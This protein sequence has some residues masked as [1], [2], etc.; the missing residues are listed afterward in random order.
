MR[1]SYQSNDYVVIDPPSELLTSGRID[2][3]NP[4]KVSFCIPTLNNETT[5]GSCLK[6]IISQDYP[7]V[8]II[9]VDGGSSDRT[10]EIAEPY[11]DKIVL[12]TGTLGSATQTAIDHSTGEVLAIFDDDIVIPHSG[13]LR[14]AIRYFNY[15]ERTSTVWPVVVAPPDASLTARLYANLWR[16]TF[17]DRVLKGRGNFGGGNALFLK[18][19]MEEIGGVDRSLH[20]GLDFDWAKKLKDKS[21]QVVLIRD[22]LYHDTMRSLSEFA[23]KQFVGA[24]AFTRDGFVTTGL[25][26]REILYEQFFLGSEGMARGLIRERDWSWTLYPLF[27][28]IRVVA[29]GSTSLKGVLE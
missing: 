3:K 17:Q 12:D 27:V 9:I 25:S 16:I 20:W 6:S 1:D 24:R 22:A 7:N 5:V 13:W 11:A 10:V 21:N 18:R 19:C 28:L 2:V 26:K 14:N 29:Y 8:E 23:K 15:S 4:P